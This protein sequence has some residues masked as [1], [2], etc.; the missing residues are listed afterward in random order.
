MRRV[1]D[2][3]S[4]LVD[5]VR[6]FLTAHELAARV[7]D[8]FRADELT[9]A[10]VERLVADSEASPLFRLKERCHA[11]FRRDDVGEHSATQEEL[12]DLAVG[13]LFHEAMKLREN[14][15][16]QVAYGPK[17]EV[18]R[19]AA[20]PDA[21]GL[22]E[23]FEKILSGTRVR[24]AEAVQETE[25][26]L[27]QTRR[28]FRRLLTAHRS[29]R[30][31]TRYLVANQALVAAVFDTGLESLLEEIHGSSGEGFAQAARSYV[32]SG[33]F[34]QAQRALDEAGQRLNGRADLDA[35]RAYVSGM[36]AYLDGRRSEALDQLVVWLDGPADA[37]EPETA[38]VAYAAA[39]RISEHAAREDAALATRAQEVCR[40]LAERSPTAVRPV[41]SESIPAG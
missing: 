19:R 33:Y 22:F 16:Q 32:A 39:M 2:L 27:A 10:D 6:D 40:R 3:E 21:A 14:L 12:F 26:L 31:V 4:G 25:A 38:C 34:E 13:A 24:L 20:D 17:V 37:V 5:I 35:L 7:A 30:L 41:R 18:L 23:E 9:F 15:Y 29:N 1:S 8:R 36:G 11:L 28:Q